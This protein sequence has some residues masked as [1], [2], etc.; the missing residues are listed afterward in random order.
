MAVGKPASQ[1]SYAYGGVASR[2][3]DGN[4]SGNWGDGSVTHTADSNNGPTGPADKWVLTNPPTPVW[5]EVDL[6]SDFSINEIALNNRTDHQPQRL[7]NFR[8]PIINDGI[9]VWGMDNFVASGSV[10]ILYSIHEDT[11]GF[12]ATG[13]KVRVELIGGLNNSTFANDRGILSLAEVRV[14][15]ATPVLTA[16][17]GLDKT[18]NP[19]GSTVTLGGSPAA[20]GGT[21]PYTYSWSPTTGLS[22]P[23]I[24]NPTA[25]PSATTPY[26]LTVTDSAA[27][28]TTD[29]VVFIYSSSSLVSVGVDTDTAG[30]WR[31]TDV[32]KPGDADNV[33]GTD[34]YLIVQYP[35][36]DPLNKVNP[37]F[38]TLAQLQ[39]L[40]L[41]GPG[42]EARQSAFD[43]VALTPGPGLADKICGDYSR[44]GGGAP[45]IQNFFTITL[46]APASFRLGVIGDQTT[47]N[48][49][50]L[51][52]ESSDAVQ[53]TGPGGIDS[54]LV[55]SPPK[56]SQNDY[57]LF[58]ITGTTGDVFTIKGRNNIGWSANALGGIFIDPAPTGIFQITNSALDPNTGNVTLTFTSVDSGT[59]RV[60]ASTD[61]VHWTELADSVDGQPGTTD[62]TDSAYAPNLGSKRPPFFYRVS[63]V[64]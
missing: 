54:G 9:E 62:Y 33:Y 11:G 64:P 20:F 3:V 31:S 29:E 14:F 52:N 38:A 17:A 50:G 23:N 49:P 47:N 7:S 32:N 42:N 13:D 2:A 19:G 40:A 26:T 18:Y 8:V 45:N 55:E 12:I 10:G 59:Y 28:T 53:V 35:N 41:E 56:N 24:A 15:G 46:T 30:A 48:P 60:E 63:T 57:Y 1:T 4:T 27:A 34:G 37:P 36:G 6:Q 39:D 16:D 44:G 25:S 22:D 58:D 21:P 5:W 61:L 43:D 51:I